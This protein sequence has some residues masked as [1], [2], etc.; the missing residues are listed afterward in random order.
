[1]DNREIRGR[2]EVDRRGEYIERLEWKFIRDYPVLVE[3]VKQCLQ[4]EPLERP[5]TEEV[6]TRL[7]EVRGEV[8]REYGGPIKLD[9]VRLR[10]VKDVRE[11]DRRIEELTQQLTQEQVCGEHRIA[12]GNSIFIQQETEMEEMRRNVEE[13]RRQLEVSVTCPHA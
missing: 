11:K 12:C 1:M 3:L 6:L 8:E 2:S 9:M 4:N 13:T 7:Q 5:S 10:L